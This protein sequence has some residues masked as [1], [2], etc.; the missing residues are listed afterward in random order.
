[1]NHYPKG[2]DETSIATI[3]KEVLKALDYFHRNGGAVQ[4]E[5][6]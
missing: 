5:C 1:L 3:L 2:L 4:V 6:S